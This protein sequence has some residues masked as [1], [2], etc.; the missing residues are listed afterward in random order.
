MA[1]RPAMPPN[2]GMIFKLESFSINCIRLRKSG[3]SSM[4]HPAVEKP[5]AP[6]IELQ[7]RCIE[8]IITQWRGT[9]TADD[10]RKQADLIA[11]VQ[12]PIEAAR[13]VVD[14]GRPDVVR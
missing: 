4:R 9:S 1:S 12:L 2:A 10:R 13:L 7:G 14:E 8:G 6:S 5:F 3:S 11:V